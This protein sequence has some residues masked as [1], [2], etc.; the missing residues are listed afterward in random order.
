MSIY[1]W[2]YSAVIKRR[3][4]LWHFR[5]AAGLAAIA[6]GLTASALETAR[7]HEGD[8]H[9]SPARSVAVE[10]MPRAI[11][12]SESYEIVAVFKSDALLI[13]LDRFADNA[14]VTAAEIN[15]SI[16]AKTITAERLPDG[17][18]R[19]NA[20]EFQRPGEH[21]LIFAIKEG[22]SNDLLVGSIEVPTVSGAANA[23]HPR[24]PIASALWLY[25]FA[26]LSII[27][28]LLWNLRL[29]RR[30]ALARALLALAVT[31]GVQPPSRHALAHEGHDDAK[32]VQT[33]T[34]D[35]PRR[36][37]NGSVFLPKPSQRLLEVRTAISR[38]TPEKAS[39]ALV[40]R[41][42]AN[43]NRS[44]VVQSTVGGRFTVPANGL[45]NLGQAVKA[46][47]VLGYVAPRFDAID[48][49]NVVQAAGDLDQQITLIE[50]KLERAR[51]LY[52]TNA[53]PR[54]DMENAEIQ[55]KGLEKRR[56]ALRTS[57][58]KP[59]PVVAPIDGVIAAAKVVGGQVVA[60]QDVLFQIV[61]PMSL[62]VEAFV[63]D[64]SLVGNFEN[65]TGVAQNGA[66]FALSFIG[67]GRALQQQSSIL[68]FEI[69]DP[70]ASLN[71]G[72]PVTVMTQVG[73]PVMAIVLS[74]AAVVRAANGESIVW[75][76]TEPER[77]LAR[78]V[79]VSIFDGD[80]VLVLAGLKSGER[81]VVQSA[82]LVNQVR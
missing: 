72:L 69:K 61:D 70:P 74:K 43:P 68:H 9:G 33:L 62:W 24:T 38:E 23:D 4:A 60:T 58:I 41:V 65:A 13:Y 71:V 54:A 47:D 20:Q 22:T 45:P 34:G 7:A 17:V 79:R 66:G 2:A 31:L 82:E 67:R 64:Q 37:P 40:G 77:F 44:G 27:L 76:H 29:T 48:Q 1:F 55:L 35:M 18:F 63:F 16:G 51:R 25:G 12:Q 57:Q 30:K 53:G 3:S 11:A 49:T 36:L 80:R 8:D 50:I 10:S 78:P 21:E 6:L 28:G 59:E 14:P 19:V 56:A 26:G 81:V 32:P 73:E 5:L 15:V 75:L 39:T 46:G 42:I 52:S